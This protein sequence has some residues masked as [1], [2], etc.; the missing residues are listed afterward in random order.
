MT[1]CYHK[2]CIILLFCVCIHELEADETMYEE[3]VK[4]ISDHAN[5]V[6][7]NGH[8]GSAIMKT[9]TTGSYNKLI[10]NLE[11]LLLICTYVDM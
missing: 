2:P 3:K 5:K 1:G 7:D 9:V 11:S 10:I 6:I 4:S 8:F